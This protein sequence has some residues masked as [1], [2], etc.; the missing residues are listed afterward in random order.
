[1]TEQPSGTW[2][3]SQSKVMDF[4]VSSASSSGDGCALSAPDPVK[5]TGELQTSPN[6]H[7]SFNTEL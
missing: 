3:G 5:S 6:H 4:H 7:S 1:M 2:G